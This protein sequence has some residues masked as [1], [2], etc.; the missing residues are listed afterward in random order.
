M[1]EENELYEKNEK[2]ELATGEL[3]Q[4]RVDLAR[5]GDRVQ[6]RHVELWVD[7]SP[8]LTLREGQA[9]LL[10]ARGETYDSVGAELDLSRERVRQLVNHVWRAAHSKQT[11]V[12]LKDDKGKWKKW[13]K[14]DEEANE[15]AREVE[16]ARHVASVYVEGTR[17]ILAR[18]RGTSAEA[19][20]AKLVQTWEERALK[21]T[22]SGRASALLKQDAARD[23]AKEEAAKRAKE[24]QAAD[25]ARTRRQ[26]NLE[27]RRAER[28]DLWQK[29][30][31]D[32]RR[33]LYE[34]LPSKAKSK[35]P[36]TKYWPLCGPGCTLNFNHRG[37]H[38][39]QHNSGYAVEDDR[40][41]RVL[42]PFGIKVKVIP[43]Q[44]LYGLFCVEHPEI[45]GAPL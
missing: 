28:G 12:R 42:K 40:M 2:A 43:W 33:K 38:N 3:F 17:A 23:V 9:M 27:R 22:D 41:Q 39:D 37:H 44:V 5:R 13:L 30:R 34:K 36:F 29:V 8:H 32:Q 35:H 16:E 25:E 24:A 21:L 4:R 20:A 6:L 19:A 18:L 1:D 26:E 45:P 31:V 7:R 11:V 15:E 10:Y 14:G